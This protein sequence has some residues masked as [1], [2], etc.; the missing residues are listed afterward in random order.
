[1][2]LRASQKDGWKTAHETQETSISF[3]ISRNVGQNLVTGRQ[4]T[5]CSE[6]LNAGLRI[7]RHDL[8]V[9]AF[10]NDM[11]HRVI[12]FRIQRALPLG[13]VLTEICGFEAQQISDVLC[14]NSWG[15]IEF[16]GKLRL[17]FDVCALG[18]IEKFELSDERDCL[19]DVLQ[20]P[21]LAS[22]VVPE[23]HVR[24]EA[25]SFQGKCRSRN[26]LA[27]ENAQYCLSQIVTC[28]RAW[29]A[30]WRINDGLY[31]RQDSGL[32]LSKQYNFVP[33]LRSKVA[34]QNTD[35]GLGNSGVRKEISL[36]LHVI[37]T[38]KSTQSIFFANNAL[39][40]ESSGMK[41][42]IFAVI[43]TLCVSSAAIAGPFHWKPVGARSSMG[44]CKPFNFNYPDAVAVGNR[45]TIY[46]GNEQGPN[47]IQAITVH[48]NLKTLLRRQITDGRP[49]N[50]RGLSIAVSRRDDIYLA[51]KRSGVVYRLFRTGRLHLI[52]GKPGVNKYINGSKI[53]ARLDAPESIAVGPHGD[54][55]VTDSQTVREIATDGSVRTVA[56][57]P[58]AEINFFRS[59]SPPVN[60][61]GAHATFFSARYITVN[62]SGR[63]VVADNYTGQ[64]DGQDADFSVVREINSKD[65]VSTLA[66][67]S[68][69]SG[70]SI[71]G[72]GDNAV[73]NSLIGIALDHR[74]GLYTVSYLG[75]IRHVSASG[76]V[77]TIYDPKTR[78]F[79]SH[80]LVNPSAVATS[81]RGVLY[82]TN[83]LY[84]KY[85]GH[86][87]AFSLNRFKGAKMSVLCKR[88]N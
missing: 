85:L 76:R 33:G 73:F 12:P 16:L 55:F 48:G 74:G 28:L 22:S 84:A 19:K 57:I 14:S 52:A 49:V 26:F 34:S 29:L 10:V 39:I 18:A 36:F 15:R 3:Q 71:D 70:G 56:G 72:T 37:R 1:M 67:A 80:N 43:V 25:S 53:T 4:F 87:F 51:V 60:G 7:G 58:N 42:R 45:G 40:T 5:D 82:I 46:I 83:S 38:L 47:A 24:N 21:T 6:Q 35:I 54:V 20:V 11:Q 77:V 66:G 9:D 44:A 50:L 81:R 88:S 65:Y 31:S 23:H 78:N 30:L 63:I 79:A 61:K 13:G 62:G 2:S 68:D 86:Q 17:K 69:T 8:R 32:A 59:P 75:I 27:I 41:C 64:I